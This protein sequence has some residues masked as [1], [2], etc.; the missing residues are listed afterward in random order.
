MNTP[1]LHGERNEASG[2]RKEAM[3]K[4]GRECA[5]FASRE[6]K[7]GKFLFFLSRSPHVPIFTFPKVP[8]RF[9]CR[10]FSSS[11]PPPFRISLPCVGQSFKWT[12]RP[13]GRPLKRKKGRENV[14][15]GEKENLERDSKKK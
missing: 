14:E 4:T 10:D 9:I 5:V 12:D 2:P 3:K 8:D 15:G 7:G 6:K 13:T 11:S 1:M